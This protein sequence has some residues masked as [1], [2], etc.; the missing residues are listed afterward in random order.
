MNDKIR[1]VW[2]YTPTDFFETTFE[3]DR[4]PFHFQIQGGEITVSITDEHVDVDEAIIRQV[5]NEL[6][7]IFMGAQIVVHKPFNLPRDHTTYRKRP[8]GEE[9]I[10]VSV[11]AST[12]VFLAAKVD[13]TLTDK[14]GNVVADTRADREA[15]VKKVAELSWKY[16]RRDDT[17][18]AILNSYKAAVED[19]NNYF[20]HLYEV[21]EALVKKF[22]SNNAVRDVLGISRTQLRRLHYLANEAPLEENRHRGYHHNELRKAAQDELEDGRN[23]ARALIVSYLEYL[24]Q[25]D[26]ST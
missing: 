9:D 20:I 19:R 23:I 12:N 13:I 14:N 21:I 10:A 18:D 26:S 8:D 7:D 2:S 22:G 11:S 16:R 1:L 5:Y 25:N 3:T 24:D 6:E 15:K 4:G 17:A